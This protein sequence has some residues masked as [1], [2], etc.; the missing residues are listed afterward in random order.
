MLHIMQHAGMK[1]S[2]PRDC[3]V[4]LTN[5]KS[6]IWWIKHLQLIAFF[7]MQLQSLFVFLHL[8]H[9]VTFAV[10]LV[11]KKNQRLFQFD[12]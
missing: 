12:F 6:N 11:F 8:L 5:F 4:F 7:F 2:Q 10:G 9:H 3:W 1:W